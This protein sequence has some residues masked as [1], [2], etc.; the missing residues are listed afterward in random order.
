MGV[1]TPKAT[2]QRDLVTKGTMRLALCPLGRL[3]AL[4]QLLLK[5]AVA[6]LLEDVGI[7]RLVVLKALLQWGQMISCI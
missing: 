2:G 4:V 1:P 3:E 6:R 7:P 5:L